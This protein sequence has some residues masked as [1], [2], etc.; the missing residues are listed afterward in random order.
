MGNHSHTIEWQE[1]YILDSGANTFRQV[2]ENSERIISPETIEMTCSE[3]SRLGGQRVISILC[4]DTYQ[5]KICRINTTLGDLAFAYTKMNYDGARLTYGTCTKVQTMKVRLEV[6]IQLIGMLGVL[7]GL[8]F[9]GLEMKQSQL[10]AIGAQVQA[11]TEL[12]AQMQPAPFEG[13]IDVAKV[14]L[15]DWEEM[16]DDQKLAK[17]MLQRYRWILLENTFQQINL[18]LLPDEVEA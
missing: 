11:R 4:F 10:I 5:D 1:G 6:W 3:L 16:T 8:V 12:R 17:G 15:L 18:G 14:G 9:V 7:G 2:K 13:N